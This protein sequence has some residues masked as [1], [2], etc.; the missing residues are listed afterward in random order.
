MSAP[1]TCAFLPIAEEEKG[2]ANAQVA[3]RRINCNQQD[4]SEE[5]NKMS[6]AHSALPI[7]SDFNVAS[8]CELDVSDHHQ[9][10]LKSL[11]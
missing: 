2:D 5:R 10:M 4:G 1:E 6:I 7:T 9:Q 3:K 8:T 11:R